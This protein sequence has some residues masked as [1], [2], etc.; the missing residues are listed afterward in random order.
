MIFLYWPLLAFPEDIKKYENTYKECWDIIREERYE[1]MK[2]MRLFGDSDDFLSPRQFKDEWVNNPTKEWDAHAMAVHAAM[3]DRMDQE[4]GK[5]IKALEQNNELDNTLIVFLSD[6]GASNEDCQNYSPGENDRPAEMRNGEKIIYPRNKEVL[7]GPQNVFAS[8]GARWA[9][10]ANTPFRFWKAK[11]YEGGICTPMIVHWPKGIEQKK[12]SINNE[13]A[14]VIDIMATC[15]DV[16][17]SP[18]PSQYRGYSIIPSEGM[19]LLPVFKTGKRNGHREICFEHFNEKAMID[20]AG[21]KIVMPAES[22]KWELYNLNVDRSELDNLAEQYPER[23]K[24]MEKRYLEWE[25]RC[26]VVPRP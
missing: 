15:L 1:R 10:V 17:N 16:S 13:I 20:K 6:N 4:I 19:S 21:W 12:G 26:M 8:I 22:K 7:P 11:T 9:N 23:V 3:I 2:K 5:V 18:Y 25:K 24:E 14:H